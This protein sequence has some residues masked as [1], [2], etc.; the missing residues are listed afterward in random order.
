[1]K[2][3]Q[4]KEIVE[5]NYREKITGDKSTGK[6]RIKSKKTKRPSPTLLKNCAQRAYNNLD[7]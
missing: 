1:M 2:R 6:S 7:E 4:H 5:E 3:K